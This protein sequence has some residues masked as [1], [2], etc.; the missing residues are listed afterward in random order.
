MDQSFKKR[1]RIPASCLVCR[2]RKSK[3]D[4]IRPICGSCR[5]KLIAH[6]CYYE[7]SNPYPKSDHSPN[8]VPVGQVA[9]HGQ[10][11]VTYVALN[12]HMVPVP[13]GAS[14]N[15]SSHQ[16]NS[17]HFNTVQQMYQSSP[18][19]PAPQAPIYTQQNQSLQQPI[20][21]AHGQTQMQMQHQSA[22][23]IPSKGL[24]APYGNSHQAHHPAEGQA[25][26]GEHVL[27]SP[28]ALAPNL[29][30]S[31]QYNQNNSRPGSL[32][33]ASEAS[34]PQ[35]P[36]SRLNLANS[37]TI[38]SHA[39]RPSSN[40]L[41]QPENTEQ[42]N[43]QPPPNNDIA[44]SNFSNDSGGIKQ[45]SN[46]PPG[47]SFNQHV[48]DASVSLSEAPVNSFANRHSYS[49]PSETARK[50]EDD[51]SPKAHSQPSAAKNL[52]DSIIKFKLEEPEP[53][54]NKKRKF[55]EP[56][57]PIN[58]STS[59][60]SV[61]IG[62]RLL[63][64][65]S[66]DKLSLFDS[67][68]NSLMV[69]GHYRQ[70]Q[71]PLSYVGL[72]KTDPFVNLI[73]NFTMDLFKTEQFSKYVSRK[74]KKRS[75]SLNAS[76]SSGSLNYTDTSISDHQSNI[77]EETVNGQSSAG[78]EDD[79]ESNVYD[80][81]ALIVTK[82]KPDTSKEDE[83]NQ[84]GMASKALIM[85][86]GIPSLHSLHTNKEVYF[87]FVE[88]SILL[89]LPRKTA[90]SSAIYMYFRYVH[91]FIPILHEKTFLH[92]AQILF[93]HSTDD[94]P[95]YSTISIKSEH[96]QNLAGMLLLV[97]RLGYMTL[98]PNSDT[99]ARYSRKEQEL[100][101]DITRFKT[102]H[103]MGVV[104]LCVPEEKINTK[105]T[106]KYVQC[107]CLLFYYRSVAPNDCLGLSGADSQLLF[108]S[109]VNHA[110]SI[111]LNRD[112]TLFKSIKSISKKPHSIE[113]WRNLWSFIISTDA[114]TS[115][116]CGTPLKVPD[117]YISDV[118][119]PNSDFSS[120]EESA[121]FQNT[122]DVHTGYRRIVEK[123]T[124]LKDKPKV[125]DIL[126]E[127][128]YLES[129]F[130]EIFGENFFRDSVCKSASGDSGSEPLSSDKDY[131]KVEKFISF[132]SM[133]VNLSCLYYMIVLHYEKK[134]DNNIETEMGAGIELFK[135]FIKSAVQVV[136]IMTYAL[137][138]SQELFGRYFDW[139]LTARIERSMI[140]THSFATCVF[141]R[142]LNLKRTL[143]CQDLK[144]T[145]DPNSEP[146][147]S[148]A[149][150]EVV[151]SL[152]GIAI[153]EAELFVGNFRA[154]SKTH[155]NSY[156]LYVMAYF[157]LKQCMENPEHVIAGFT[158]QSQLFFYDGSN[159]LQFLSLP[160]LKSMSELCEEFRLAKIDLLRRKRSHVNSAKSLSTTSGTNTSSN[161]TN[162]ASSDAKKSEKSGSS[163]SDETPMSLSEPD[164]VN[165]F[166]DDDLDSMADEFDALL[167]NRAMYA[168]EN[169]VNTYG[170]LQP[171]H[172]DAKFQKEVF[173]S[174]SMIGNDELF[175]LFE[176]YGDLD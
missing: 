14:N 96:Q 87:S 22:F 72:T 137:D 55:L 45:N 135:I 114:E 176:I 155:I 16:M 39:R 159:L 103:Y 61:A 136:Y 144:K 128:S 139:L 57:P 32:S 124:N 60:V 153:T 154:L 52:K 172:M 1:H 35:I 63:K 74:K 132:I 19:W 33:Q 123:I 15:A 113:M 119:M 71:G 66:E 37:Q 94:K 90:V 152:F 92:E 80:E 174:Q 34:D 86:P 62:S 65:D 140:K 2:K 134:V 89:V 12:P 118:N 127:T 84:I 158:G 24:N 170:V 116:Y 75:S 165:S 120:I 105:S 121:Y 169:T 23:T 73:R 95:Y 167:A 48:V 106:F 161:N 70:Q 97:I 25:Y 130:L 173:D 41:F 115:I 49:A 76:I 56:E 171:R 162:S 4:R 13:P 122:R 164:P 125:V 111:G 163:N 166:M 40:I 31:L 145:E 82:I 151:D 160:E 69:E 126:S 93:R 149:R 129:K 110:L 138:N 47:V 85:L 59:F 146:K 10:N 157:A 98:I 78:E 64:I 107:L 143:A 9:H 38:S 81:D 108:G 7:E 79:E 68:S 29:P 26:Q 101:K 77:P 42:S 131:L 44:E 141:T 6:L 142:I 21:H 67:T 30:T 51:S 5:K 175:Q 168:N 54:P 102:D 17:G 148:E 28:F 58:K 27:N 88:D 11:G 91:P 112:P 100:I 53:S 3:C 117:L 20:S 156:R 18:P 46:Q 43:L 133:R 150:M 36:L 50:R 8:Y 99:E 147:V 83:E 109:I 104:N